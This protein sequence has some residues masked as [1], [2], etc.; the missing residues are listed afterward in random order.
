M[1]DNTHAERQILERAIAQYDSRR[2]W[3]PEERESAVRHK[4]IN[5]YAITARLDYVRAAELLADALAKRAAWHIAAQDRAYQGLDPK[6]NAALAKIT[7]E[8]K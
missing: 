7:R 1:S 4:A 6:F 5:F 2:Q 3:F 8:G